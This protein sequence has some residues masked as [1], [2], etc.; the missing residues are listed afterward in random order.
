M[1]VR[2]PAVAAVDA[3]WAAKTDDTY[4]WTRAIEGLADGEYRHLCPVCGNAALT[5]TVPGDN[6]G[7]PRLL[8]SE[9]CSAELVW[10][11]LATAKAPA[12][13]LSTAPPAEEVRSRSRLTNG[14]RFILDAPD[15]V[16][17]LWAKASKS[18][19]PPGSRS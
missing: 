16:P 12:A 17:A 3:Y 2:P 1:S 10:A 14:A 6:G 9:G 19:G 15:D 7:E 18:C 11:T 8:C 13:P 5:I 4:A